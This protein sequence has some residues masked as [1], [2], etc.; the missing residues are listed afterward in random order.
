MSKRYLFISVKQK[1]HKLYE[2]DLKIV[3]CY[4]KR[5]YPPIPIF[6][7]AQDFDKFQETDFLTKIIS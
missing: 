6:S 3:K 7:G 5:K 2:R 1:R 4:K